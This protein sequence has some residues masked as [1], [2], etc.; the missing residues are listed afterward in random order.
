MINPISSRD[1]VQHIL[2]KRLSHG[3]TI[4]MERTIMTSQDFDYKSSN[5]NCD[6]LKLSSGDI[7]LG[8]D[9]NINKS[10]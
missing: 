3:K 6:V 4:N 5:K 7:M 8:T 2:Y 10:P 1:K 9:I